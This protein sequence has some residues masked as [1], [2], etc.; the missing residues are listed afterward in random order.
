MPEEIDFWTTESGLYATLDAKYMKG[1]TLID[2]DFNLGENQKLSLYLKSKDNAPVNPQQIFNTSGISFSMNFRNGG[3]NY[4]R[5]DN[6]GGHNFLHLHL[7][8]GTQ[9]FDKDRIPIPEDMTLYGVVSFSF[10]KAE[11]T[12]RWKFP[13]FKIDKG[14]DFIGMT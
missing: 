11:D 5:V 2:K 10:E 9:S 4:F 7:E 12:I 14:K 1:E 6:Q 8:S 3:G 13:E